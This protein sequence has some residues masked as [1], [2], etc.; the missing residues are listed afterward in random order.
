MTCGAVWFATQRVRLRQGHGQSFIFSLYAI[1]SRPPSQSILTYTRVN[2]SGESP[3]GGKHDGCSVQS[4][5]LSLSI[6]ARR[7]GPHF[8]KGVI[9]LKYMHFRRRD[10]TKDSWLPILSIER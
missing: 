1:A 2:P 8:T 10:V 9:S 7:D 3:V 4:A 6:V 5:V